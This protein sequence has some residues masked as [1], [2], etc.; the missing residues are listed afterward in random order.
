MLLLILITYTPSPDAKP[1]DRFSNIFKR[2]QTRMNTP[3]LRTLDAVVNNWGE[4][5]RRTFSSDRNGNCII[6]GTPV[7]LP[8]ARAD[9]VVEGAGEA[10]LAGIHHRLRRDLG[11]L[12]DRHRQRPAS[13]RYHIDISVDLRE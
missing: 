8:V 5:R 6:Q 1:Q 12:S 7:D 11:R 4:T 13:R 2:T 9:T 3:N 10:N